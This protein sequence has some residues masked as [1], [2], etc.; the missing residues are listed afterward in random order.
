MY[1]SFVYGGVF[2]I[3]ASKVNLDVWKQAVCLFLSLFLYL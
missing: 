3:P 2:F 1:A